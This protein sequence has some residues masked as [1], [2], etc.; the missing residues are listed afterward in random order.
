MLYK[1]KLIKEEQNMAVAKKSDAM[2]R[3]LLSAMPQLRK[4][5]LDGEIL[6]EVRRLRDGRRQKK[7]TLELT[8]N[9]RTFTKDQDEA[10]S[11][12]KE[13]KVS[14]PITASSN[15]VDILQTLKTKI[16]KQIQDIRKSHLAIPEDYTFREGITVKKMDMVYLE[17]GAFLKVAEKRVRLHM[18]KAKSPKTND[19]Y[20]GIEIEFAA[21]EDTET[22][23][24]RLFEAG[25]GRYVCVKRDGSIKVDNDYQYAHE[26]A[27]LCKET[28]YKEIVTKLCKVVNEQLRIR[29]DKSCGLHV[30]L[31]MRHRDPARS[32]A[33]L[34]CMQNILYAMVPANR[35]ASRYSI[36]VKDKAWRVSE[37]HY[38]GV[39]SNPYNKY[40]TIEIRMHCG[41]TQ[42]TKII[43]WVELLIKGA[44]A[45][46]LQ[47]SP[48]SVQAAKPLLGLSDELVTYVESRIAK[49][50]SQHK[51]MQKDFD[52]SPAFNWMSKVEAV[53][54]M[55]D[56]LTVQEESE[57]A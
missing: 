15:K 12:I 13:L 32:Y 52:A 51:K 3:D 1:V 50:A 24:N 9:Y 46:L 56:T 22:L 8:R 34:V 14:A 26:I 45:Q 53:A 20:V 28:E 41:T 47:S 21:K 23:C 38:D 37:S 55:P 49:F 33:N 4:H 27:V 25:L 29:V 43:N 7:Y 36:P 5:K 57:V 31:D 35:K 16:I 54:A 44:D 40:R 19:R 6:K 18:N 30:H 11:I 39:S 42:A 10:V 48:V 17:S 2:L